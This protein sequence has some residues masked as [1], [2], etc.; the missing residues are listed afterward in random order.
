MLN[1]WIILLMAIAFSLQIGLPRKIF[2][3]L[4]DEVYYYYAWDRSVK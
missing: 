3:N 4:R 2:A 1:H